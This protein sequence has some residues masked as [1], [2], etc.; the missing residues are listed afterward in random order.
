[1]YK[2]DSI[3]ARRRPLRFSPP[4]RIEWVVGERAAA[5]QHVKCHLVAAA[6]GHQV[7][8]LIDDRITPLI[9]LGYRELLRM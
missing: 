3:H 8:V 4:K 5:P 7:Y 6:A 9:V 1:M 2:I